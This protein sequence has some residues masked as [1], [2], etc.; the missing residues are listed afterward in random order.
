MRSI[1]N[2][3]LI[4]IIVV[5]SV[6]FVQCGITETGNPTGESTDAANDGDSNSGDDV[7]DST[8]ELVETDLLIS[9]LCEA[10]YD[11]FDGV[12]LT[13]CEESLEMDVKALAMFGGNTHL[14]EN[15]T[16]VQE[17]IDAGSLT[18]DITVLLACDQ[19]IQDVS[20]ESM[21]ASAAYEASSGDYENVYRIIPGNECGDVF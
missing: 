15:F 14:Y 10:V 5:F 6:L 13:E 3:L 2:F 11:C 17:S 7:D 9:D 21:I 16:A 8:S 1:L 20:C 18:V 19:A 4:I 12:N